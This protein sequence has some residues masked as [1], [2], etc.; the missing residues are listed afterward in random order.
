MNKLTKS[1]ARE[2][3]ERHSRGESHNL[4]ARSFEVSTSTI[5][6]I[7]HLRC[8]AFAWRQAVNDATGDWLCRR[9]QEQ[10]IPVDEFV[11]RIIGERMESE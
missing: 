10:G 1:Q 8:H 4:L 11:R 3:R 2:I 7:I 6:S 9:A 5:F